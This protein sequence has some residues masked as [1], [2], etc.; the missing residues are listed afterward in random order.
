MKILTLNTHSLI[1]KDYE[2]K[3][4]QFAEVIYKETPDIFALQEVNQSVGAA[5]CPSVMLSGYK[6]C[7][8]CDVVIRADN[9][10]ARLAEL[11]RKNG[12]TY[13][14]TWI[15]IKLGYGIYDEG[16]ALFSN[17]PILETKQFP[18]SRIQDYNNWKSRK[19]LGIRT[20]H[21][22]ETWYYTVHMG[23]WDDEEEPFQEQW[24]KMEAALKDVSGNVWIM[25]DFNNPAQVRNEGYDY[26]RKFGWNDSY[27][28]AA[29]KDEGY[30]V[31][32]V[33]DGWRDKGVQ[34]AGMRIDLIWTKEAADV[35][36]SC[37][38]CN[39]KNYPIVSD[40]YGVMIVVEGEEKHE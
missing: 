11:L 5:A 18:T 29:V 31:E 1:E 16:L 37:V 26:L 34:E 21:D 33:I 3:L 40:H 6:R 19:A 36:S 10:A 2:K 12:L 27:Y 35:K 8:D 4:L 32:G 14:W 20:A 38:I 24:D 39:G 28:M 15:P 30:T 23:W 9:H 13:Y 17:Q 7:R 22:E 25:G